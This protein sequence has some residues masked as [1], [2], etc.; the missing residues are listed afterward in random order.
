MAAASTPKRIPGAGANPPFGATVFFHMPASYDG[1][2]P[3][4]LTFLDSKGQVVRAFKLHLKTKLPKLS[5]AAKDNRT[6]AQEK[7]AA[8][9]KLTAITAG[10]QPLP[11]ESALSGCHRSHGLLACRSRPAASTTRYRARNVV[12]GTYTVVLDYN[13]QKSQ[14][15]FQVAL[16]PRL[17]PAAGALQARLALQ[18]RIHDTLSRLDGAINEA[19]AMRARLQAAVAHHRIDAPRRRARSQAL[20]GAIDDNVDMATPRAK[21]RC[22]TRPSC[23]ATSPIL[24]PT[25]IWPTRSRRRPSTRCMSTST[26][27]P[28][29]ASS[30]CRR[31]WRRDGGRSDRRAAQGNELRKELD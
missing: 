28:R 24:P 3:V 30:G 7:S 2:T 31:R 23:A 8:E 27:R 21:A 26:A 25:S 17:H 1:K 20:T 11:V 4:S 18:L 9:T 5:P 16:D 14:R 19:I 6:P 10:M 15:S 12:P 13:G 22:C 29:R